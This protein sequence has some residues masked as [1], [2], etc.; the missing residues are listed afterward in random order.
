LTEEPVVLHGPT[1]IARSTL[2]TTR[3]AVRQCARQGGLD[4]EP[5]DRFVTAVSEIA[6]NTIKHADGTGQLRIIQDDDTQLIAEV[7]DQ[8][9]GVTSTS[10]DP[11]PD[12]AATSGRGLW[13]AH[14][15]ADRLIISSR[16]VGTVVRIVMS[17]RR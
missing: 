16:R 1:P 12:T 4:D 11:L 3:E 15:L 5:T 9:P 2:A 8:G 7:S 14:K 13:L 10:A 6:S 17:L